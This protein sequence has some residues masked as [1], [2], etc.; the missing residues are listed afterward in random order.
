MILFEPKVEIIEQLPEFEGVAKMIEKV[1]RTCWAS[2]NLITDNSW[3]KF[4]KGIM[5]R[6]HNSPL[7]HGTIYLKLD[8]TGPG[9]YNKNDI[10][11]WFAEWYQNNPYSV[12][13]W[14]T[15][16]DG[17]ISALVTT[18]LRVL[19]ENKLL[20]QLDYLCMPTE[21]HEHRITVHFTLQRAISA[22]FNR[23]RVNSPMEQSSRYCNFSKDK[24]GNEIPIV[25]SQWVQEE[26]ER[27]LEVDS[28]AV[29][30][31]PTDL[32]NSNR[33]LFTYCKYIANGED[34]DFN[35][36]DYWWFANLACEYSY[37]NILRLGGK[38]EEARDILPF[39]LKS[40]LYHTATVE[41]WKHFFELRAYDTP[42]NVP[43]REAKRL[44]YPLYEEFKKRNLL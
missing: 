5:E 25:P 6:R 11:A 1:G 38:P 2:E 37:M 44:A 15:N 7:E 13:N 9:G 10:L 23:H 36:V 12:V 30:P 29:P 41:Q 21:Y 24:F 31:Y 40:E 28:E 17:S 3:E 20:D 42:G 22:E 27:I 16:D 34:N 26:W 35:K 39:D 19:V 32:E 33:G 4:V 8:I 43:H 18:N 14:Y